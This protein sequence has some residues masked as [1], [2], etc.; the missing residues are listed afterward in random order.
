MF[1]LRKPQ[2]IYHK[3]LFKTNNFQLISSKNIVENQWIYLKQY[4]KSVRL[5]NSTFNMDWAELVLSNFYVF[6]FIS[7]RCHAVSHAWNW[8]W[9]FFIL[10]TRVP[11]PY[12][13]YA[14]RCVYV[15]CGVWRA[16]NFSRMPLE[17]QQR[18]DFVLI[19][20]RDERWFGSVMCKGELYV[21]ISL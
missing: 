8:E 1:T 10:L 11:R 18:I 2:I 9:F 19:L 4:I 15:R 20:C 3:Q 12:V 21:F 16:A 14:K 17:Q 13:M 6:F 7:L 5:Q